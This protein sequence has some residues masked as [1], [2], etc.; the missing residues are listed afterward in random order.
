MGWQDLSVVWFALALFAVPGY[1]QDAVNA[2][3]YLNQGVQAYKSARY[4]QA[5]EWFQRAVELDPN[6]KIAHL[7]L[8]TAYMSQ[9]IPGVESPENLRLAESAHDEFRAVLTL[10]PKD[11]TATASIETEQQRGKQAHRYG[12]TEDAK[13]R[14]DPDV[15]RQTGGVEVADRRKSP[16]QKWH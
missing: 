10:D 4:A 1:G 8:A 3:T 13:I 7:Y 9:Y 6:S 16:V 5:I 2:R 11:E 15:Q 12:E 14:L